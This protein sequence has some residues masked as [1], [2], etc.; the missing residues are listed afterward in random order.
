VNTDLTVLGDYYIYNPGPEPGG[1]LRPGGVGPRMPACPSRRCSYVTPAG[2]CS[3]GFGDLQRQA[4]G[5]GRRKYVAGTAPDHPRRSGLRLQYKFTRS[6]KAWLTRRPASGDVDGERPNESEVRDHLGRIGVPV[7]RSAPIVDGIFL[8]RRTH[9]AGASPRERSV[10]SRYRVSTGPN[11]LCV[12]ASEASRATGAY[13]LRPQ[14]KAVE[15][16]RR[17]LR[18][19]RAQG[20]RRQ[21]K[22]LVDLHPRTCNA[23]A[24]RV[25]VLQRQAQHFPRLPTTAQPFEQAWRR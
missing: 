13:R 11:R 12:A 16:I 3:T 15:I 18:G 9:V 20:L 21:E 1:L 8:I 7:V 17:A 14:A 19:L 5:P 25:R 4:L 10:A 24:S 22:L 6:F 23:T 2:K